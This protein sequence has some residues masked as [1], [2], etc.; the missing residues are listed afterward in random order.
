MLQEPGS[1]FPLG[2]T[3]VTYEATD[4]VGQTTECSFLVD[5]RGKA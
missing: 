1:R 5:V 2:K 4:A 3:L